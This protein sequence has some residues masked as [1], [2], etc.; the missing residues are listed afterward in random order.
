ML[1]YGISR[2]R[3]LFS[4]DENIKGQGTVAR[5]NGPGVPMSDLSATYTYSRN[6]IDY[7]LLDAKKL[8]DNKVVRS[9]NLS[10]QNFEDRWQNAAFLYAATK[11]KNYLEQAKTGADEYLK[12]RVYTKQTD[13]QDKLSIGLFFWTSFTN[14]WMELYDFYKM[15]GDKKYLEA[16]RDGARHYTEFCWMVPSIPEGK[17][18]V[19]KGGE[20]PRYRNGNKFKP[21]KLPETE[22]EAWKVSEIGLTPESSGTSGGHRAI[23]MAHHAPFMMRI[24]ADTGDKF[25]HDVARNAVV[26]RYES[27]PG[28]H[29]NAGRTNAFEKKNFCE[30][31]QET[32]NAHTSIHYNHP[33]SHLAMLWDYL[34]SDV[35][36]RSA[37]AIDFPVEYS[38]GYAYCRSFV[39]GAHAGKFYSDT[40]VW[41]YMPKDLLDVSN[42]QINYLA[43]YGN[44]NLYVA[45]TNQ[46]KEAQKFDVSFNAMKS[47]VQKNKI[48]SARLWK[49]NVPMG[50]VQVKDGKISLDVAPE[51]IT[52]IAIS[53]VDV[54]TV[55]QSK[56]YSSTQKWKTNYTSVGLEKDRAVLFDFGK[57]LLSVYAWHE[58]SGKKYAETTLHYSIDGGEWDAQTKKAFPF[59]FTVELPANASKFEY[60]FEYKLLDGAAQKTKTGILQK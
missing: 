51:G 39:Y 10:S 28:Y 20:V 29:I 55:F 58:G 59:E 13:F 41:A 15:T 24:A 60:Y 50:Q 35:Y 18:L 52:A 36:Y 6:R 34:F 33:W 54:K 11:D 1:E 17:I 31:P 3:F 37:K 42:V 19:N 48:Y 57:D 26:G 38:E 44:G 32:L 21:M 9:I 2:E 12:T 27:F 23:F 5:L 16:A 4:T 8:Y 40:N 49:G 45:F 14:Q 53:G 22:I 43:A 46:S 30:Q 47:Y 56:F 7:M 25:L